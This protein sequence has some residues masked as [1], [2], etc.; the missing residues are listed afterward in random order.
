MREKPKPPGYGPGLME[1]SG[2]GGEYARAGL[3][4]ELECEVSRFH[5]PSRRELRRLSRCHPRFADLVRVFPGAA[6][7]IASRRGPLHQRRRALALVES[8]AP[9]KKIALALELPL[10]LRRLPP[11]AF[12]NGIDLLPTGENFTRRVATRLPN[13]VHESAFWLDTL[14]FATEAASE[15]FALWLCE[16]HLNHD[17]ASPQRMFSV[18]AAYAWF[19]RATT[20][21]AHSLIVVP[22]R[23]E[24]AFD[25]A[26]CA[27]KSWWNRIRLVMQLETGVIKDVWLEPSNAQGFQFQPLIE[28][29]E[30]L[31]ESHAMQNCADQFADRIARDKC[32]LF[33]IRRQDTRVATM[34][35]G[36]HPRETGVLTIVQLKARH[37]MPAPLEIWQAAHYWLSTQAGLKRLPPMVAPERT[38]NDDLWADLMQP[39]REDKSGAPWLPTKP[40]L[41]AFSRIDM[42]M[43]ELA[44]RGSVTS[45]LF[46]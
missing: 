5:Q 33:S 2:D 14:T 21:R 20:T 44:R 8:G 6:Y 45:W 42:D 26:L 27:A 40:T 32:R 3:D 43:S 11:E 13:S 4:A 34:E 31:E 17:R 30:I 24:I 41:A 7:A 23:P 25:T 36:P 9:L 19:S 16:Q 1:A 15:D 29:S 10:W 37:N 18:L 46:N 39:Y 38:M 12:R 35:I 22:W 28:Q